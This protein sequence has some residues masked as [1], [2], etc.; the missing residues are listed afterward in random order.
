MKI[1]S[2]ASVS[3]GGK[4]TVVNALKERLK[5]AT[6]LYFD[7]YNFDEQITSYG[8]WLKEGADYNAYDLE[9]LEKDI[10]RIKNSNKFDYLILDYPFS[11]ANKDIKKYI[12]LSIFIDTPLDIALSR[13]VIRDM[14]TS[15]NKE[16]IKELDNYIKY[17]RPLYERMLLDIKPIS[18]VII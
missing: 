2:I 15:S 1:I 17:S 3:G 11:Y 10:I 13:R 18:D 12:D 9:L 4:T 6:M 8:D 14:S 5:N 16:I 7:D